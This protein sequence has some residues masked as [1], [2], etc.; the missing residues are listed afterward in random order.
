MHCVDIVLPCCAL[1]CSLT[2]REILSD[3]VRWLLWVWWLYM[4]RVWASGRNILEDEEEG[5][6]SKAADDLR[7]HKDDLP[8]IWEG[9]AIASIYNINESMKKTNQ[10]EETELYIYICTH[11]YIYYIYTY[12]YIIFVLVHITLLIL[13]V[14]PASGPCQS[15][16]RSSWPV[17]VQTGDGGETWKDQVWFIR[18]M[19]HVA[20]FRKRQQKLDESKS[21]TRAD[22]QVTLWKRAGRISPQGVFGCHGCIKCNFQM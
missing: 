21:S 22:V 20:T 12:T 17:W 19:Q 3:T 18:H 14:I 10:T 9:R 4:V 13:M 7:R 8:M 6:L 5:K 15:G 2:Y 1:N 16:S 11:T